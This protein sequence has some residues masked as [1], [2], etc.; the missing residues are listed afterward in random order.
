MPFDTPA[1][2]ARSL[3]LF[4]FRAM[5]PER[6]LLAALAFSFGVSLLS[7][8]L[9]ALAACAFAAALV[10]C[11]G[12]ERSVLGKRLLSINAFFL[13]LWLLLPFSFAPGNR[14]N[15]LHLFGPF[16]VQPPGIALAL[17][18]TLKGNALALALL[19]LAGSSTIAEN[20][21]GLRALRVPDKLVALL[22]VSHANLGLVAA[23]YARLLDAAKL[24]GF[25]PRTSLAS[26]ATFARLIALLLIRAWQRAQ[27]VDEAMRLRGFS[28]RFPF[29]P[30]RCSCP[31]RIQARN[32]RAALLLLILCCTAPA[33]LLVWNIALGAGE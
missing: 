25:A 18:I 2:S 33:A 19:A 15:V 14:E 16:S 27:R 12:I 32:R 31:P 8:P 4:S 5:K 11:S 20:G 7:R 13:L 26:Y 10:L 24:R 17:L 23:E 28:G 22:L 1:E 21:H 6:K 30:S 3:P 29:I 9:P